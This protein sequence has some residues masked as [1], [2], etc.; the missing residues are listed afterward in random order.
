LRWVKLANYASALEADI[1]VERLRSAGVHAISRTND[2]V[3]IFGPGY[4]GRTP[5]GVD[6]LVTS[7]AVN[8]AREVLGTD[9]D[10]DDDE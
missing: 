2:I 8:T 10:Y 1:V 9:D 5:R 3:G 6:V 7:D 4:A